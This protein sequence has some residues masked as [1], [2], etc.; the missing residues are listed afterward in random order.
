MD[1]QVGKDGHFSEKWRDNQ[2]VKRCRRLKKCSGSDNQRKKKM[3]FIE[4]NSEISE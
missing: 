1:N 2:K 4:R 3:D